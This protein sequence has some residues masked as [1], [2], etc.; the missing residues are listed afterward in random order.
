MVSS[1][2]FLVLFGL[3]KVVNLFLEIGRLMFEMIN[4]LLYFFDI[5]FIWIMCVVFFL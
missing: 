4:L 1:V 3:I 5:L 2:F